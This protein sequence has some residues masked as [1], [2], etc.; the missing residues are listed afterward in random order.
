M[1]TLALTTCAAL[2]FCATLS[3]HTAAADEAGYPTAARADFVFACMAANGGTQLA[4]QRC[5]CAIDVIASILPYG[6]YEQAETVLRMRQAVGRADMVQQ[7]RSAVTNEMVRA[8]EEAKAEAEV[9][10]F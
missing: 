8:L 1:K 9:R 2:A 10:C 3:A 4:L 5:A 7:F 6:R